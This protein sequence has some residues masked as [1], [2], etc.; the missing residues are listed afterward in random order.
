[1]ECGEPCNFHFI[2]W[3]LGQHIIY[4]AIY[5]TIYCSIFSWSHVRGLHLPKV[6]VLIQFR[7][8]WLVPSWYLLF[9]E[10]NSVVVGVYLTVACSTLYET[11]V[12]SKFVKHSI[13][14]SIH[15]ILVAVIGMLLE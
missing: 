12:H 7:S 14:I 15:M 10:S 4:A 8:Y 13:L 2:Q 11:V 5:L 6:L 1:M 3:T 9:Q